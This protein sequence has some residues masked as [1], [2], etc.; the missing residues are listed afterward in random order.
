[1]SFNGAISDSNLTTEEFE[2]AF[3]SLKCNKAASIDTINSN[4]VLDTYDEIKDIL[5]LIFKTSLQQGIFPNILKISKVTPLFISGDT[6]NV[7][8]YRPISYLSVFSKILQRIM[9]NG[10]YKHLKNSNLLFDKQFG[11]F[12]QN[13]QF[14]NFLMIISSSF[15]RGEYTLG[16]FIDLLKAFDTVDHKILISKLKHYRI[17]GKTLKWLKSYLN[18]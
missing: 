6:E 3:K 2:T 4:I 10:I 18:E 12:K 7:F 17:K 11:F 8:N 5:F 14:F 13:I 1:M 15:E 9:Y 16:I